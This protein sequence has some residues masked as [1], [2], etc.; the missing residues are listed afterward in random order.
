MLLQQQQMQLQAQ[1][2]PQ[3]QNFIVQGDPVNQNGEQQDE[4]QNNLDNEDQEGRSEAV[5]NEA[6]P[7]Q[8][9]GESNTQQF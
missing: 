6:S 5:I 9:D 4:A 1:Q 8:E 2:E 7:E 3:P